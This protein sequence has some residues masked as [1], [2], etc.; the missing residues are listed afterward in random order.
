MWRARRDKTEEAFR[1]LQVRPWIGGAAPVLRPSIPQ[2]RDVCEVVVQEINLLVNGG[3]LP[4]LQVSLSGLRRR[5]GNIQV[6]GLGN[7]RS[8]KAKTDRDIDGKWWYLNLTHKGSG[9]RRRTGELEQ[10]G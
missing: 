4:E 9:D 5:R 2:I 7:W 10:D 8:D 3:R 6:A 1:N